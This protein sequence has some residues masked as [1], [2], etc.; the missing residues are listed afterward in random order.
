LAFVDVMRIIA[1]W[2]SIT[3]DAIATGIRHLQGHIAHAAVG[4]VTSIV[5]LIQTDFAFDGIVIAAGKEAAVGGDVGGTMTRSG[6]ICV[7]KIS[8]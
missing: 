6:R 2:C 4:A 1:S 5:V 8:V 7:C 3:N